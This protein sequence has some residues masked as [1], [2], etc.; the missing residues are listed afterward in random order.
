MYFFYKIR[1]DLRNASIILENHENRLC[2]SFIFVLLF[3]ILDV[4]G[5]AS[6]IIID[7]NDGVSGVVEWES[8]K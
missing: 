6:Q 4:E 8:T 3:S 1:R 7:A 5:L 2:S